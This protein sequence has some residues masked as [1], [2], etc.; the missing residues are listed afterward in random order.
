[1]KKVSNWSLLCLFVLLSAVVSAQTY[2]Q[3]STT[4]YPS[5]GSQTYSSGQTYTA[6]QLAQ[7]YYFEGKSYF[8][9]E[10]YDKAIESFNLCYKLD[11]NNE[12]NTYHLAYAWFKQKKYDIALSYIN[13][14]ITNSASPKAEYFRIAANSHDILGDYNKAIEVLDIGFSKLKNAG[15]L[16]LDRGVIEMIRGSMSDGI[17]Y[18][19]EGIKKDPQYA[20]NY[21][22]AARYYAETNK[23]MW[24]I[25]YGE[26]YLNVKRDAEDF[27]DVA[28]MIFDSYIYL[29]A[30]KDNFENETTINL[31][32]N[33]YN[34]LENAFESIIATIRQDYYDVFAANE[35]SLESIYGMRIAFYNEWNR[36]YVNDIKVPLFNRWITIDQNGHLQMYNYWLFGSLDPTTYKFFWRNSAQQFSSFM[37]WFPFNRFRVEDEDPFVRNSYFY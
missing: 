15:P 26:M 37:S 20:D 29:L 11:P 14:L 23:K 22:W 35:I 13:P 9:I 5:S 28:K 2:Y 21:L 36:Q 34:G 3:G 4:T 12:D 25:L 24:T 30:D 33:R 8:D 27:N 31:Q 17:Y 1:M 16:Y 7:K 18:W 6:D 19:E 10:Q 32:D